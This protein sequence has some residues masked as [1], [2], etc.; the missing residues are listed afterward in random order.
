[1]FHS[2]DELFFP[3]ALVKRKVV[4]SAGGRT[5]RFVA[6]MHQP[7][8]ALIKASAA[9]RCHPGV[10]SRQQEK[11]QQSFHSVTTTTT[12]AQK[13]NSSINK[14]QRGMKFQMRAEH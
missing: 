4:V 3:L 11:Q 13:F 14:T 8:A 5:Q 12:T 2:P 6:P 1:M 10:A 7:G 9:Q